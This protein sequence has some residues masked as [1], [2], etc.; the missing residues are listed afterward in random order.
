MNSVDGELVQTWVD[1]WALNR[2]AAPVERT[3]WGFTIDVGL[4]HRVTRLV[5]PDVTEA[6]LRKLT[7]TITVPGIAMKVFASPETV[8][9][10]IAPG[11]SLEAPTF[12][13]SAALESS[14]AVVPTGY[15]LRTWEHGPVVRALLRTADGAFA[16]RGQLAVVG[17][18][19][20]KDSASRND[21]AARNDSAAV[22][23]QIETDPA[24]RRKGLGRLIM[25]TLANVAL[26][27]GAATGVLGA[28]EEGRALYESLGWRVLCPMADVNRSS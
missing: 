24:H 14:D 25:G 9:P 18:A 13:M 4:P 21:R 23:D 16:A 10:W 3:P 1:G 11:W 28:T 2:G 12:L 15:Q 20:R 26:R 17:G 22:L 8:A 6:L 7:E 5:V 19:S 27:A